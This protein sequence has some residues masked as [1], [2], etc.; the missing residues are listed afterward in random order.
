MNK[1]LKEVMH[2][3]GLVKAFDDFYAVNGINFSVYEGECLGLLGPNGAGKTTTLRMMLGHVLPSSGTLSVFGYQLPSQA[4]EL[5]ARVG[6]VPQH[7]NLDLDFT[8]LENLQNYARFFALKG[9]MIEQKIA[10]L[11]EFAALTEKKSA[12]VGILSGGMKRRLS[13]ARALIH[14]PNL[15]ILDEPTT[16][17][18]PQARQLL[19]QK[20][21]ELKQQGVTLI[22]TTHY[23]DEA[24]RL[25]DRILLIDRG[26]IIAE[27]HPRELIRAHIEAHVVELQSNKPDEWL[28]RCSEYGGSRVEQVGQTVFCYTADEKGLVTKLSQHKELEFLHRPANL[29]DV[30]LKLTGR[31]L[32]DG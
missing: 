29:E 1:Q 14:S 32:R 12:P 15:L 25:C 27:G 21:Q 13:L 31:E 19:W 8:V 2:A 5:R 7:D 4:R 9:P 20:L 24:E 26:E 22:L 6:V 3:S 16:G 17:L 10:E 18:D 23:M 30:F 28:S 11:I